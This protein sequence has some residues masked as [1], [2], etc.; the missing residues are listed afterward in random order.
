VLSE[1]LAKVTEEKEALGEKLKET[2]EKAQMAKNQVKNIPV[3]FTVLKIFSWK[4]SSSSRRI[5]KNW[6]HYWP[7]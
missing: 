6:R 1:S 5:Q 4:K 3:K 2:E 7:M